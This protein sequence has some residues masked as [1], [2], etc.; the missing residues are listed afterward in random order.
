MVFYCCNRMEYD[1]IPSVGKVEGWINSR[2]EY[3]NLMNT[4]IP[5]SERFLR[6]HELATRPA[7]TQ[8]IS[9]NIIINDG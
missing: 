9:S 7:T 8:H 6:L 4:N 1:L 2:S 3:Q 5:T